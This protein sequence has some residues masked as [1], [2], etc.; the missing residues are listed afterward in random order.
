MTKS[1][2]TKNKNLQKHKRTTKF[3]ATGRKKYT[4]SC[5]KEYLS[6]PA[7]CNHKKIKH[8]PEYISETLHAQEKLEEDNKKC[9]KEK[10]NYNEFLNKEKRKPN[11]LELNEDKK[12]EIEKSIRNNFN[13]IYSLVKNQF[14]NSSK[15]ETPEEYPL[16]KEVHDNWEG[17][18]LKK[19]ISYFHNAKSNYVSKS[20]R[21]NLKKIE[22]PTIDKLFIL[23]LKHVSKL[24]NNSYINIIIK[25]I[26]LFREYINELKA[27][28]VT[29]NIIE[30]GKKDFTQLFHAR[31]LT[32]LCNNFFL[33]FLPKF[34]SVVSDENKEEF[35][36]IIQHFCYWLFDN[37]Y[38]KS[39]LHLKEKK[40][41]I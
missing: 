23:Y 26:I 18:E 34:N 14:L 27:G 28:Q 32:Y 7:Y 38:A 40:E 36:E 29:P 2:S 8:S 41:D 11:Y 19:A 22:S 31:E 37:H 17:N 1:L 5:G 39:I 3:E 20:K 13:E 30:D 24:T 6:Q 25:F 12:D 15:W 33:E 10:E 21:R 4:C 16:Y 35:K 9:I